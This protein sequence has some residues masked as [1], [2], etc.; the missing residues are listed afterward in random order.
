MVKK[1]YLEF[2][3]KPKYPQ[4]HNI[5]VPVINEAFDERMI[6]YLH[7]RAKYNA[8]YLHSKK[9]KRNY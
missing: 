5:R 8:K 4:P 1:R 3:I 2:Q 7:A 9:P 6:E